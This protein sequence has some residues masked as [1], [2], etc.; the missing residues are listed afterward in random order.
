MPSQRSSLKVDTINF[1]SAAICCRR[2]PAIRLNMLF[3][4]LQIYTTSSF[5][6]AVL[7]LCCLLFNH[8]V[9]RNDT[10]LRAQKKRWKKL[11]PFKSLKESRPLAERYKRCRRTWKSLFC[12]CHEPI[13]GNNAIWIQKRQMRKRERRRQ[14][15]PFDL[16]QL[17]SEFTKRKTT[18]WRGKER[19]YSD[20]GRSSSGGARLTILRTYQGPVWALTGAPKCRHSRAHRSIR[21]P[22]SSSRGGNSQPP[23]ARPSS[24]LQIDASHLSR[25]EAAEKQQWNKI[26]RG[27]RLRMRAIRKFLQ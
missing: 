2:Q 1:V 9:K 6:A 16:N 8:E 4:S 17:T 11:F 24:S 22:D 7:Q 14:P 12:L 3:R 26:K 25:K 10:P 5:L 15:A 18:E 27:C 23:P 19:S 20:R 21:G 13:P